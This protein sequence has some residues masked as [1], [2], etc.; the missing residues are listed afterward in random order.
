M[1]RII[2]FLGLLVLLVSLVFGDVVEMSVTVLPSPLGSEITVCEGG[3]CDYETIQSAVDHASLH[4]KIYVHDGI[5]SSVEVFSKNDISI[6]GANKGEVRLIGNFS[7]PGIWIN[8]SND[9]HLMNLTVFN[10]YQ[11]IYVENSNNCSFDRI[12]SYNNTINGIYISGDYNHVTNSNFSFNKNYDGVSIGPG[13]EYNVINNNYIHDNN[14]GIFVD[15]FENLETNSYS[16]NVISLNIYCDHNYVDVGS[17]CEYDYTLPSVIDDLIAYPGPGQGEIVLN[18]TAVGDNYEYGSASDYILKYSESGPIDSSNWNS[19]SV[20]S[21]NWNPLAN[22]SLEST[23]LY[24]NPNSTY[25]FALKAIDD[26]NLSSDVSNSA[27]SLS[28]WHDVQVDSMSCVNGKNGYMCNDTTVQSTNYFYDVLNVSGNVSNSGNLDESKLVEIERDSGDLITVDSKNILLTKNYTTFVEDLYYN[29]SDLSDGDVVH[30]RL[31]VS[32][33]FEEQRNSRVFSIKDHSGLRWY[34][35]NQ[36]P[37]LTETA[38]VDFYVT[39]KFKNNNTL[40]EFYDYPVEIV[41]NDSFSI[42]SQGSGG[43]S[44]CE[45]DNKKCY[46]GLL[47]YSLDYSPQEYVW[48]SLNLPVGDYNISVKTGQHPNDQPPIISRVVEVQ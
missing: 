8:E 36:H 21:Y 19:T 29:I 9:I 14:N 4:D 33:D 27:S 2:I 18:W 20:Y 10:Y 32:D 44:W 42:T 25:W 48:W 13:S 22:G 12:V 11:G 16:S 34:T 30:I 47:D 17:E 28:P 35:D 3:T 39:V 46:Y 38:N 40:R 6:V 26:S 15:F 31:K 24:I 23:P 41:I 45:T 5:Y 1:K 7:V 43:T 37:S